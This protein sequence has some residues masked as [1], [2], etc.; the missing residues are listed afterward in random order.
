MHIAHTA[1]RRAWTAAACAA[2]APGLACVRELSLLSLLYG[3]PGV[4]ELFTIASLA[5]MTSPP[6]LDASAGALAEVSTSPPPPRVGQYACAGGHAAALHQHSVRT[7]SSSAS[8]G[9]AGCLDGQTAYTTTDAPSGS[10]LV[11]LHAV[12][13]WNAQA[14][15]G[16]G[17]RA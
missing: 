11:C 16:Q 4:L 1:G 8:T 17:S 14:P 15:G 10:T 7:Q 5:A 6:M 9:A 3:A 12:E 13:A 2:P